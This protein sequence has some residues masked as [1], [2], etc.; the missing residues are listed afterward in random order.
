MSELMTYNS[1]RIYWAVEQVE[2]VVGD[3]DTL[4]LDDNLFY[5]KS[6]AD[7]EIDFW[8]KTS[9]E[10]YER[11][12]SLNKQYEGWLGKVIRC[13]RAEREL[14]NQ[15]YKRCLA[16]AAFCESQHDYFNAVGNGFWLVRGDIETRDKYRK[17]A[18]DFW[19]KWHKRWFELAEKF[20]P[21]NSTAQQGKG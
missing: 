19:W 8:K 7:K 12:F 5:L 13:E 2:Q 6:E 17:K 15:K 4:H 14:R 11:W 3:L 16:I 1:E 21:A 9:H 18:S 20:K 10:H